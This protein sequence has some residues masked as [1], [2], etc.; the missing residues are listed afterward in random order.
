MDCRSDRLSPP[1]LPTQAPLFFFY[2]S[3]LFLVY[4]CFRLGWGI[5]LFFWFVFGGRPDMAFVVDWALQTNY[6]SVSVCF[7]RGDDF[8]P[9]RYYCRYK[10]QLCPFVYS[11][12]FFYVFHNKC[13]GLLTF[14]LTSL[15]LR[16]MFF[17]IISS[18]ISVHNFERLESLR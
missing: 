12:G 2:F 5:V 18:S 7:C 3:V 11:Y 16:N 6:L 1:P 17:I 4:C 8:F 13:V 9:F 14:V 10:M 15:P